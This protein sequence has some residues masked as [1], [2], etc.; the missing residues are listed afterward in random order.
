[1]LS[2]EPLKMNMPKVTTGD[3]FPA[4]RFTETSADTDLARVKLLVKRQ[5][6]DEE[7]ILLTLDSDVSGI[8]II[9]SDAGS[10]VYEID[11]ISEIALES[12]VYDY[13]IETTDSLGTITTEFV[14]EWKIL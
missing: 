2:F 9:N 11:R 8:T 6:T 7:E 5:W 12:G 4:M 10:W 13:E 1:M 14:G 3:T